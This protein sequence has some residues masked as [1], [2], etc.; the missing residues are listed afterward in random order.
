MKNGE[1]SENAASPEE[2]IESLKAL[3]QHHKIC[4]EVFPEQIPVIE[5]KPLSVGFNLILHGAHSRE[6][7]PVPGCEKCKRLYKDLRK[8]AKW[9]IPKVER[10]SRYEI[11]LY[12]SAI[13]Y[14]P[15]RGNRPEVDLTIQIVHRSEF[16][17]PVDECEVQCLNE[18]K[19][20]LSELGVQEKRW[21]ESS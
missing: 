21:R 20:R 3:V 14:S 18:M 9:I 11:S 5:D 2:T 15:T 17:K 12:D 1:K 4:W 8:I 19:A 16:D 6:D 10:K 13:G 7:H